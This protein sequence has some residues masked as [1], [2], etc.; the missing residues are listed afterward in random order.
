M[1]EVIGTK[2]KLPKTSTSDFGKIRCWKIFWKL[3]ASSRY[4]PGGEKE[5]PLCRLHTWLMHT[6]AM[7]T[8]SAA[9]VELKVSEPVIQTASVPVSLLKLWQWGRTGMVGQSDK[10]LLDERYQHSLPCL[11]L[12]QNTEV[13]SLLQCFQQWMRM[14]HPKK[15]SS[16]C[17]LGTVILQFS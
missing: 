17:T 15:A 12:C 16:D 9:A 3:S 1:S 7:S 5:T 13:S 4:F 14:K 10:H 8:S 11:W 6:W 2:R